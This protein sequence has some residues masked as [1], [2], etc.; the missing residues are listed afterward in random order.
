MD[1][2]SPLSKEPP[3]LV[4]QIRLLAP[5]PE[6]IHERPF[7]VALLEEKQV[8]FICVPY[9]RFAEPCLPG[10]IL[11]GRQAIH[12]RVLCVWNSIG[13]SREW[14]RNS[15]VVDGLSTEEFSAA[16]QIRSAP[17]TG[18]TCP[19]QLAEKV[20]PPCWH[21]DDPRQEYIRQECRRLLSL[22][23]Q[24]SYPWHRGTVGRAAQPRAP[25]GEED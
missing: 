1:L 17:H 5:S 22:A 21:P 3:P 25:D 15:W 24:W 9:S 2:V 23:G 6:T 7:Y 14:L 11:T 20:G 4:G 19:P 18:Y 16:C 12:L 8:D 13:M 10:E